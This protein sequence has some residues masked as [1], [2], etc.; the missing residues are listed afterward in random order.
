MKRKKTIILGVSGSIASYKAADL[1]SSLGK[2]GCEVFAVMTKEAVEFISPLTL[3][4]LSGN[5]VYSDMFEIPEEWNAK[6]ISLAKRADLI[7]IAPATANV[8]GKLAGGICDDLLCCTVIA[9]KAPVLIAPAMNDV[10]YNNKIVQ[11]NISKLKKIGYKFIGP[12]V[13]RLACG[14]EAIGCMSDV[15]DII[16]AAGKIL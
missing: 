8:I 12:R 16:K 14:Y 9:S 11:E 15:A 2:K 10:M 13:G 7:L 3:Q 4:T 1:V 6:H 5:R